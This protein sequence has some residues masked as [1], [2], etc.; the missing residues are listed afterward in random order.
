MSWMQVEVTMQHLKCCNSDNNH[1]NSAS[2]PHTLLHLNVRCGGGLA[3][4]DILTN[5]AGCMLCNLPDHGY[6]L[7]SC[8]AANRHQ[9]VFRRASE[10]SLKYATTAVNA[11][12]ARSEL[13]KSWYNLWYGAF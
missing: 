8:Q 12:C 6:V 9:K 1:A 5:G 3:G 7:R 13:K 10:R 2:G 11:L 4:G